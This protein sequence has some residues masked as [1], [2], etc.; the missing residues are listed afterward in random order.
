MAV[1]DPNKMCSFDLETTSADP[2]TARIVTSALVKVEVPNKEVVL[3]LADPGIEI[4]EAA[5]AIHGI[6]TE[7][8]RANGR[9]HDEVVQQTIADIYAAWEQGF[10]L[11]VYNATFDLSVL[12]QLDPS[13]VVKGL[14]FDPYV[15]DRARVR[16][17]GKRTLT[18][19]SEYYAVP[20]G[21]DA[22]EASA[23]ALAA[24]R[25]AW[26]MCKRWPELTQMDEG[27][28]ME[29][30]AIDYFRMQESLA[31]Y[32]ERQGRDTSTINYAWPV[33]SFA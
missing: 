24:A 12:S 15:V 9:P 3:R 5:T 2:R 31:Q 11:I 23:D 18:A 28:L 27:E 19:V 20:V 6:T 10:T 4:P 21:D 7:Y 29:Q 25:I 32:F 30:Q 1:F 22:H 14:V 17:P 16:R 13:F 26:Q 33:Q 8:A